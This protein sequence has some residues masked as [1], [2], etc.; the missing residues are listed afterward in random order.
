MRAHPRK[1]GK[2]EV[3]VARQRLPWKGGVVPLFMDIWIHW[4]GSELLD[5]EERHTQY[6]GWKQM[7]EARIAM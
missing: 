1:V 7:E 3:E 6:E 5:A 4:T 2:Q